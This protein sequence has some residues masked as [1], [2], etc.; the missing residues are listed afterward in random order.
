[1]NISNILSQVENANYAELNELIKALSTKRAEAKEA[2]KKI[3]KAEKDS[4]K[5]E[6]AK[7]GKAYFATL[8][9]GDAV[10]YK[11]A[12]GT[13]INGTVGEVKAGAKNATVILPEGSYEKNPARHPSYDQIIVPNN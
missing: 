10:S 7:I 8:S 12:D 11:R 6:L 1:M 13:I 3:V 5:A 9:I 4:A 2:Y